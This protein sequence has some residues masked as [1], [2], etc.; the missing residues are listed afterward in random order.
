MVTHF[1]VTGYPIKG[2]GIQVIMVL[3]INQLFFFV[4]LMVNMLFEELPLKVE[5]SKLNFKKYQTLFVSDLF[6]ESSSYIGFQNLSIFC[7]FSQV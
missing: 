3:K 7:M 6:D 4:Q 5:W 1:I 2:E